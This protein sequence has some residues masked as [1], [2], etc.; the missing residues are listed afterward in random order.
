MVHDDGNIGTYLGN[1]AN[2]PGV[3]VEIKLLR[4]RDSMQ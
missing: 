3:V 4:R 2:E 1:Q